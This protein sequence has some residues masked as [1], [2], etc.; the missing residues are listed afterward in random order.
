MKRTLFAVGCVPLMLVLAACSEA[1][2]PVVQKEPE[3]PAEPVSGQRAMQQMYI[4]ARGWARGAK[5]LK[6]VDANFKDVKIGGGKAGAW[7]ATFVDD[8]RKKSRRFSY[9]P[10]TGVSSSQEEPWISGPLFWTFSLLDAKVDSVTA[11]E[12]ALEKG[13]EIA[14]KNPDKTVR[15]TLEWPKRLNDPAWRV[16]WG[17][18]VET[19]AGSVLVSA[20]TGKFMKTER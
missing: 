17:D 13:A 2:K 19:S 15:C 7:E 4:Q 12:L 11:Y 1:P 10:A 18:S 9:S 20:Y 5:L 16:Y 8:V 3:K 6:V 14:K